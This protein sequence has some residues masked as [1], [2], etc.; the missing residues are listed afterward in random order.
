M[1]VHTD[2][3]LTNDV[4]IKSVLHILNQMANRMVNRQLAADVLLAALTDG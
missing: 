1:Y 3:K 2:I 4:I